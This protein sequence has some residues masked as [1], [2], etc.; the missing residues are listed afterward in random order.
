MLDRVGVV[1]DAFVGSFAEGVEDDPLRASGCG[2]TRSTIVCIET[3]PHFAIPDQPWM[4][5]CCVICSWW[6]KRP[7]LREVELD[8]IADE[9]VDAQPIVDEVAVEERL[10]LVGV[11]VLAVVPEVRGDVCFTVLDPAWDRD[12]RRGAE[13]V[14]RSPARRAARFAGVAA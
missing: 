6:G 11:R 3:P 8:G 4:Q 1:V 10:V 5:K 12:A 2:S 13:P 9:A 14:R 7:Q